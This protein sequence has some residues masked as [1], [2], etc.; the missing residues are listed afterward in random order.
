MIL[1]FSNCLPPTVHRVAVLAAR[2]KLVAVNVGVAISA[3]KPYVCKNCAAVTAGASNAFMGAA[4]GVPRL[5]GV[6]VLAGDIESPMRVSSPTTL[7][8]LPI[9]NHAGEECKRT[10]RYQGVSESVRQNRF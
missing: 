10:Q 6:T 9:P 8:V 1:N 2:P 7:A 3:L 4:Q 5:G